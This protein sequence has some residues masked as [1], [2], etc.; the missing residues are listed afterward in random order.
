MYQR[1]LRNV[2]ST[3]I[4]FEK[5]ISLPSNCQTFPTGHRRWYR[6]LHRTPSTV[7]GSYWSRLLIYI[8]YAYQCIFIPMHTNICQCIPMYTLVYMSSAHESRVVSYIL[9]FHSLL[10]LLFKMTQQILTFEINSIYL[11]QEEIMKY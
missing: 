3:L 6:P 1:F 5:F 2:I 7:G 8:N 10:T 4:L 9:F 11:S